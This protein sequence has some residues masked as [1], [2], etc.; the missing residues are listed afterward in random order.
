MGTTTQRQ[1]VQI[2]RKVLLRK[3]LMRWA[4]PGAAYVPFCGDGDLAAELYAERSIL[5][6]DIDSRRVSAAKAQL[7]LHAEVK[8]A[9]CDAPEW[10]FMDHQGA[11]AVAD[12]D[13]YANPYLAFHGFWDH[14]TLAD[15]VVLV[16]TD[17]LKQAV[18]RTDRS[19]RHTRFDGHVEMI[20]NA[21]TNRKRQIFHAYFSR[22][23]WPYFADHVSPAWR[24]LDKMRYTRGSV[25]YWGA[26]L[27]RNR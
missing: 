1:H 22:Y 19:P 14:A 4:V 15:R 20:P 16:F 3:R 21:N 6:A 24:I 7:P 25:L 2:Y 27:E 13:A 23:L 10:P 17:G 12:F 9:D 5:A 8:V 26:A 11:V 18:I